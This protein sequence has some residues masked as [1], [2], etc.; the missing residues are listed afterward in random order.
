MI[1]LYKEQTGSCFCRPCY[2]L[3]SPAIAPSA[4]TSSPLI[5]KHNKS[6]LC[7][8]TRDT[9]SLTLIKTIKSL[10][11][12]LYNRCNFDHAVKAYPRIG[13]PTACHVHA[14]D[15]APCKIAIIF[16]VCLVENTMKGASA[17]CLNAGHVRIYFALWCVK[18]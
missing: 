7:F 5:N 17:L 16:V 3:L 14:W 15:I 10:P 18:Q 11:S 12:D 1:F 6:T 9:Y 13:H 4:N 2:R 8:H